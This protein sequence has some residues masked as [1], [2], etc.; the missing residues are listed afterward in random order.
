MRAGPSPLPE[1]AGQF[2]R[3]RFRVPAEALTGVGADELA[4]QIDEVVGGQVARRDVL[5][6]ERRVE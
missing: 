6:R 2:E 3:E 4:E 5:A 1:G